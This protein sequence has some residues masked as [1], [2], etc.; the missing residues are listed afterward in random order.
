MAEPV[1]RLIDDP[2]EFAKNIA[3]NPTNFMGRRIFY[4]LPWYTGQHL[5]KVSG[6]IGERVGRAAEHIKEKASNAFEDIG[7]RFTKDAPTMEEGVM[8]NAFDDVP[9]PEEPKQ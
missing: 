3:M 1:E 9:V 2:G 7:E 6:A 8:Y 4:R 5:K